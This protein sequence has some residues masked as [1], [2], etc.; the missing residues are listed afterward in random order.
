MKV[1]EIK[2]Q[3]SFKEE[4]VVKMEQQQ[5]EEVVQEDSVEVVE[6]E[7]IEWLKKRET[8]IR[9]VKWEG[10][11]DL[12]EVEEEAVEEVGEEAE[13]EGIEATIEVVEQL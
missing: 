3:I 10:M 2:E 13:E 8:W 9:L 1:K 12:V 7:Q 5:Q 6:A 4:V 11:L